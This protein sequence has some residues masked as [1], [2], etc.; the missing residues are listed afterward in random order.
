M[1]YFFI[2]IETFIDPKQPETGL[3]PYLANSKIIIIAYNYYDEFHLEEKHIKSPTILKE[4]ENGEKL[5]LLRI[6]DF[7]RIKIQDDPHLKILGF[8]NLKFD[9]TFL[10][11]RLIQL[12]IAPVDEIYD[13][14]YR[15]PHYIDL[16]QLSQIIS[17][18]RF[19]DILN[20]SQKK[21]NEFFELPIKSGSGKEVTK[22]YLNSEYDKIV[23]YVKEEFS[24]ELLYINLRR[25]IYAKKT[26]IKN[27]S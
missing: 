19:K 17:N 27:E 9:M 18:H 6:Y 10:F 21:A 1:G 3:N 12:N 2:D 13:V 22:Y 26:M 8:N 4:W 5:I 23:N 15:K 24:F 7:L 16:G 25:H 20:I 11:G 14:F